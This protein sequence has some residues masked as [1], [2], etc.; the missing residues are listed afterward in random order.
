MLLETSLDFFIYFSC[1]SGFVGKRCE[2]CDKSKSLV[3]CGTNGQ[4][5]KINEVCSK[6]KTCPFNSSEIINLCGGQFRFVQCI[7]NGA[8]TVGM[9]TLITHMIA[10]YTFEL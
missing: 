4:C 1:P 7:L 8:H 3:A 5:V 2:L 10:L 9:V 6:Q